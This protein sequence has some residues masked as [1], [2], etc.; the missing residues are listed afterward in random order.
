MS[1]KKLHAKDYNTEQRKLDAATDA[2]LQAQVERFA[3]ALK[4]V[5]DQC[6]NDK[7]ALQRFRGMVYSH[8]SSTE[9]RRLEEKA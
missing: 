3:A 1:K 2:E 7:A 9:Q 5:R 8:L 6:M 4:E